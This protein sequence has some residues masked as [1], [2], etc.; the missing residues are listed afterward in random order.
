VEVRS[1]DEILR[2]LDA[3]Q[4][5]RGLWYDEEMTSLFGKRGR[6]VHKV[7][8][9]IDEKTGRML[10]V[11]KDLFIV[12]GMTCEGTYHKLCTRAVMSMMREAWLRRVA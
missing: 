7:E 12:A 6:V 8:R 4:R 10:K 1:K 3:N 9:L 5:N 2:T 11:K